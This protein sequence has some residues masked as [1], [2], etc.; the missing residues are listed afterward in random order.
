MSQG[1]LPFKYE[2][3]RTESGMTALAGLPVYGELAKVVGLCR[4]A[5]QHLGLCQSGQGWTDSQI[6]LSLVLLNL[7]GGDCVED[8]RLLEADTGLARIMETC[9]THG[10]PRQE[11]R[12]LLRRWRKEK[13]R[14]FPSPSPV[15]RFLELFHDPAWDAQMTYGQ[16]FVPDDYGALSGFA[17]INAKML[18]FRQRANPQVIA[19]LDMD[20]TLIATHKQEDRNGS[21]KRPW[22]TFPPG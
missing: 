21:L 18:S 19:T 1:V 3:D 11:R 9:Q 16:A 20:A 13:T 15:R 8:V 5:D 4:S 10:L 14:C 22:P 2:E 7:A 6:I 17:A 12:A